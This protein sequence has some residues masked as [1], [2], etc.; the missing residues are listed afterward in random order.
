M[1]SYTG[2]TRGFNGVMY[3]VMLVNWWNVERWK[4]LL[5]MFF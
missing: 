3:D 1:Y 4:H 5:E 2:L